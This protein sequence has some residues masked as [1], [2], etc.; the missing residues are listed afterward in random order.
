MEKSKLHDVVRIIKDKDFIC[1]AER[2]KKGSEGTIA[3]ICEDK[4]TAGYIVEIDN[5]VFDFLE[6]EIEAVD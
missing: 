4:G 1:P 5:D 6:D 3:E 2:V